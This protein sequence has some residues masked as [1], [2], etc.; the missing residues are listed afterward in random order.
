MNSRI[1]AQLAVGS[2]CSVHEI[3]DDR[4]IVAK[5]FSNERQC[6]RTIRAARAIESANSEEQR[7]HIERVLSICAHAKCTGEGGDLSLRIYPCVLMPRYAVSLS[8]VLANY[9]RENGTGFPAII[10]VAIARQLFEA[11]TAL[12]R[13]RVVHGDIKPANIMLRA[14]PVFDSRSV[15]SFDLVLC[16][17]GSSRIAREQCDPAVVG[18]IGYVAP[19]IVLEESYTFAAD[20]W[21]AMATMLTFITGEHPLDPTWRDNLSYDI[22]MRG[23][24]ARNCAGASLD[25]ATP[26]ESSDGAR[27]E[28][29]CEA[30]CEALPDSA[31]HD[32]SAGL[33]DDIDF[34]TKY[35]MIV[36]M[37]RLIG[38]P[39]AAFC[40]LSRARECY[41]NGAPRY[42]L[43]MRPG[44]LEQFLDCNYKGLNVGHTKLLS[45]FLRLGLRYLP[46]ERLSA[47]D[48]L[49]H[50]FF[51]SAR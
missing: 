20:I 18:T 47:R 44:T 51:A 19:E 28:A 46:Q 25:A 50:R 26:C 30:Q 39:P 14:P 8:A 42:H 33:T 15:T 11:L 24:A 35:A 2:F 16:D 4:A 38:S 37:Y 27:G 32:T 49:N 40:E 22:D 7:A 5:I 1:G 48:I 13:A 12:E 34:A 17:F 31:S 6:V 29:Q 45:T 43:T 23:I 9:N 36:L 21:A 10:I 3:A 41:Y